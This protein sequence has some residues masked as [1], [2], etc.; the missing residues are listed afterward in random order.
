ME[1][2]PRV[3]RTARHP[4]RV[5]HTAAHGR[6][7]RAADH[8]LALRPHHCRQ[9]PLFFTDRLLSRHSSRQASRHAGLPART[10]ADGET[11]IN[12]PPSVRPRHAIRGG[13]GL[14]AS[15]SPRDTGEPVEIASPTKPI[16]VSASLARPLDSVR[17]APTGDG[18]LAIMRCHG[19]CAC[20][21]SA[22]F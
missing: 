2:P 6:R 15:R 21:R 5:H 22:G 20:G 18:T 4:S 7:R 19:A 11:P 9:S 1:S 14:V 10:S 8:S 13:V 12:M 17:G 16:A 3:G